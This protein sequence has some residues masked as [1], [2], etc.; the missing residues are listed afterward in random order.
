MD[1]LRKTE[2]MLRIWFL[3]QRNPLRFSTKDLAE[4]F[5]VN[6]RTIYRD[7]RS[8]EADLVVPVYVDRGRWAVD[9]SHFLPPV[10]LTVAEA[11]NIFLAARLMLSYSHRYDPNVESTFSLLAAAVPP[12]LGE[13]IHKTLEW[14]RKLPANQ[15]YLRVLARLGEAWMSRRSVRITYQALEAERPAERTIDPYFIEPAA[16][17]HS[18]YLIAYCHRSGEI[19]NFKVERIL[20]IQLT[21]DHYTI[22]PDFDANRY[23][24]SAWGIVVEGEPQTIRLR[25]DRSVARIIRE[26]PWHPSQTLKTGKD[27]SVTLTLRVS[28]TV[29]LRSWILGWGEKVEVLEPKELR[30][31]VRETAK[32]VAALYRERTGGGEASAMPRRVSAKT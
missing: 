26:T 13:Q 4:K 22:P 9:D 30:E 32:A 15:R 6:V 16:E 24:G 21:G 2:R 8:L 23:F 18:S 14:M 1:R 31:A 5:G 25:F 19:R 10:R 7:I 17:G 12:P 3:I 28:N 27:G 29:E 11:L 20:D